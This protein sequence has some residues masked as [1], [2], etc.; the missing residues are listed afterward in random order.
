MRSPS[1]GAFD[2]VDRDEGNYLAAMLQTGRLSD[3]ALGP[4]AD[5]GTPVILRRRG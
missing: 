3:T 4:T 2:M 5:D 1:P